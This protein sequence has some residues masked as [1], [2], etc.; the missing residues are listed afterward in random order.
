MEFLSFPSTLIVG[1]LALS[2]HTLEFLSYS[3][4]TLEFWPYFCTHWHYFWSHPSKY[5]NSGLIF[6]PIEIVILSFGTLEIWPYFVTHWNFDLIVPN[7]GILANFYKHWTSYLILPLQT[8]ILAL[9][10]QTLEFFLIIYTHWVSDLILQNI[11]YYRIFGPVL[12]NTGILDLF[13]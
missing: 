9:S 2:L 13:L 6:I 8:E 1:I 4:E 7:I 11:R 3:F 12:I 5:C 10:F